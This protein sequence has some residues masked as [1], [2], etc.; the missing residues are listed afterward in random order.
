LIEVGL[1]IFAFGRELLL[2]HVPSVLGC[3]TC[4]YV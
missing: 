2:D 4:L 3:C 1:G